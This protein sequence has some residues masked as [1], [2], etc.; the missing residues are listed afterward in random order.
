MVRAKGAYQCAS[1]VNTD[2]AFVLSNSKR[3]VRAWV[4]THPARIV[5]SGRQGHYL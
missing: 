1:Q 3:K 4:D 2:G 5:V